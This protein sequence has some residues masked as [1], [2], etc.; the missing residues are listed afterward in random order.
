M[1][2]ERIIREYPD[3]DEASLARQQLEK[4]LSP[5]ESCSWQLRKEGNKP[6]AS[7]GSTRGEC[8]VI[9]Q[10]SLVHRSDDPQPI[11]AAL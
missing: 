8:Q 10:T 11:I 7:I 9:P 1:L 4:E 3:S 6:T 5:G 2:F